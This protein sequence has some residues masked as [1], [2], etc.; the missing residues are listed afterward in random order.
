MAFDEYHISFWPRNFANW[1]RIID[2]CLDSTVGKFINV[3]IG[4]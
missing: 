3:A 2:I 4:N 1:L